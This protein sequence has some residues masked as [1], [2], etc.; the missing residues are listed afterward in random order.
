MTNPARSGIQC[1]LGL[2][3]GAA[4]ALFATPAFFKPSSHASA[5]KTVSP[6]K[7]LSPRAPFYE[8][9]VELANQ[10]E[11]GTIHLQT[12]FEATLLLAGCLQSAP[13]AAFA[14]QETLNLNLTWQDTV[15]GQLIRTRQASEGYLDWTFEI[16]L[17]PQPH[18]EHLADVT[19]LS[20]TYRGS[21]GHIV[22]AGASSQ[23]H[24]HRTAQTASAIGKNP[25]VVGGNIVAKM[26]SSTWQR[27]TLTHTDD[28]G[29]VSWTSALSERQQREKSIESENSELVA[30]ML[31]SM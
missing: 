24:L 22:I 29:T 15:F 12:V 16:T 23:T 8:Q 4:I 6:T 2:V 19:E 28:Q 27:E 11:D 21:N 1:A 17:I 31:F 9:F 30:A 13:A 7:A 25:I 26:G 18:F 14:E 3:A 10:L 20:I 5:K